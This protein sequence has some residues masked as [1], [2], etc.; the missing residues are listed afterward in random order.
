MRIIG[1]GFIAQHLAR[2]EDRHEDAAVLAAGVSSIGG[3]YEEQF[4]RERDLVRRTLEECAADGRTLVLFSTASHAMY[5]NTVVPATEDDVAAGDSPYGNHKLGLE[6]MV[7]ESSVPHV[8]LRLSHVMGSGQ[9]SHQ[10]LPALVQQ[11][12]AGVVRVFAGAHRDIIDVSDVVEAVDAILAAN[13][14]DVV[15]N[16]AT[17][18]PIAI[19][20]VIDGLAARL[21]PASLEHVDGAPALTTVSVERLRQLAPSLPDLTD[22]GYLDRLLDRH[23]PSYRRAMSTSSEAV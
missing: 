16:V 12:D 4:A 10:L 8:V 18:R 7:V 22:P 1:R 2:I 11:F 9:R 20:D 5:G 19:S 3:G 6:S 23:V 15:V 21:G 13:V 14:D 17:G